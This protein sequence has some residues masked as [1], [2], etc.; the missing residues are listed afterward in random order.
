VFGERMMADVL[1]QSLAPRRT[2]TLLITI[3]AALAFVLAAVGVA[4][5]VS[6]GVTQRHRELGIRVALGASGSNLLTLLSREMG[7][8]ALIGIAAGLAG[9]WALAH[10]MA[11]LIY[12]IAIHDPLTFVA[13]P[14][15][16]LLA[17]AT[18]TYLP[19]RRALR[20]SPAEVIRAE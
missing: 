7:V 18:A 12:G 10:V 8:V 13:V 1:G 14:V 19:A 20:V 11:S 17:A 4:A 16:L 5:V 9:A 3:F 2:N 15:A 6:Y